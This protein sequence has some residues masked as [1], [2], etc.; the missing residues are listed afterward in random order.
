MD[1]LLW[2]NLRLF[3]SYHW[4]IQ[5][6]IKTYVAFP[7]DLSGNI[8]RTI[9]K[10]HYGMGGCGAV[11][12]SRP[13]HPRPRPRP[14]HPRPRPRLRPDHSRPRP[15][16]PR[17]RPLKSETETQYFSCQIFFYTKNIIFFTRNIFL[18]IFS[19]GILESTPDRVLFSC[20]YFHFF[21]LQVLW[22]R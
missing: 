22:S 16:L 1:Q 2:L 15:P 6:F 11:M 20:L 19:L 7:R 21:P 4:K 8:D 5:S 14:H 12:E 13:H 9:V 3:E 17:Q 10:L 18:H